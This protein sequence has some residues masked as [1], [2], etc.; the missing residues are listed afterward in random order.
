MEPNNLLNVD[1]NQPRHRHTGLDRDKTCRLR[2]PINNHP[3]RIKTL[4][5]L[6]QSSNK[7]DRD[8]IPLPLW[9]KHQLHQTPR[10]LMLNLQILTNQTSIHQLYYMLFHSRPPKQLLQIVIHLRRS[11]MNTQTTHV[12]FIQNTLLKLRHIRHTH[13]VT[14]HQ[15]TI[16]IQSEITPLP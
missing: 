8:A 16:L 1:L 13:S 3:N 6:R 7:V 10:L 11:W 14:K 12:T 9:Y 4:N 2:Q 5:S 15:N